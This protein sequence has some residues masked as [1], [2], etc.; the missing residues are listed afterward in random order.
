[1][2]AAI[3]AVVRTG[4][5]HG[6]NVYGI[7][8]GYEGLINNDIT[9]LTKSAV[10]NI[11]QRGGT[12]LKTSRSDAFRTKEGREKAY[13]VLQNYGIEGL[14]CIGGNGTYTG[15]EVF[16]GEYPIRVVG[17]PGT[18]DNDI[19]GTDF[20]IGFDTAV[21]TAIDAI[22]KIRDTADSHDRLFFIE[23]MG[24]HAGFIGLNAGIGSG[25]G[26]L[27]LP[28]THNNVE[29]LI[30]RLKEG[31]RRKKLFNLVIVAEGH[32]DGGAMAIVDRVKQALPD[33]DAKV[34][35]LG[36]L[37]RGGSPTG[38]DRVL[39]SRL[40]HAAVEAL[41]GGQSKVAIGIS[42]GQISHTSLHDAIHKK[43]NLDEELVKMAGILAL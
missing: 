39:A 16:S 30:N 43:S 11:I 40:G 28:E 4:I 34:T 10:G 24:R 36:H 26:D 9:P 29:A 7:R 6:L 1:M 38:A 32:E 17:V 12:M 19:Y 27:F 13:S 22:D 42:G 41:I 5:Y 37:Q 35:I 31:S 8:H 25:A 2:N 21:N 18:I 14:V 3:R 23:V 15:A 33:F 20:T